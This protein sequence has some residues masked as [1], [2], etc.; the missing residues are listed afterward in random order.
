MV[1]ALGIDLAWGARAA[2]GL[3]A[4]EATRGRWR[5]V[6]SRLAQC[7]D[8]IVAW[9]SEYAHGPC[10]VAIDAPLFIP[11]RTGSRACDLA[12][13]RAYGTY[14]I[15]VHACNQELFASRPHS[16]RIR[17][18]LE[19][20]L[21]F[22]EALSGP[23]THRVYFETY[24]HPAIVNLLQLDERIPYKKG[25]VACRRKN[26]AKLAGLLL[27]RL[28]ALDPPVCDNAA[29]HAVLAPPFEQLKGR[30]RKNA[31]DVI[32]A[33]VCAYIAASWHAHELGRNEKH[34]EP[35]QGMMIFPARHA[36]VQA[37]PA[38]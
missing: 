37:G 28:P 38:P 3:C 10:V 2:T 17:C 15:G 35:G 23:P 8:Q 21:G 20:E 13:M 22:H 4:L 27:A 7:D 36:A 9:V 11:N 1:R 25:P 24:P 5:V 18:R 26:L 34:G 14:G 29:L 6:D 16:R 33:L 12:V 30:A 19:A 31:E 32:D